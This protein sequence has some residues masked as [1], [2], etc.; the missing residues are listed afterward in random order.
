MLD[1]LH[2]EGSEKPYS[3]RK[4]LAGPYKLELDKV[5]R[6]AI[7]LHLHV[8]VKNED[9]VSRMLC[10]TLVLITYFLVE[11]AQRICTFHET[12]ALRKVHAHSL[13]L[14]KDESGNLFAPWCGTLKRNI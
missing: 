5:F 2:F 13:N 10:F 6:Q 11:G 12:C 8:F 9:L 3:H 1:P 14:C 4:Q 7:S